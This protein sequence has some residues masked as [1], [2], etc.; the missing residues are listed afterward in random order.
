LQ[1]VHLEAK[2]GME[3]NEENNTNVESLTRELKTLYAVTPRVLL[4]V[5]MDSQSAASLGAGWESIRHGGLI[6]PNTK[7]HIFFQP[8]LL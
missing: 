8:S 1:E 4:K 5:N 6:I 3:A 2:P 7:R